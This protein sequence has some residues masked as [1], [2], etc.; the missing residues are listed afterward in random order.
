MPEQLL[1][2]ATPSFFTAPWW[3]A[4]GAIAAGIAALSSFAFNAH[5]K[6]KK[7][8]TKT[9]SDSAGIFDS[10]FSAI[11]KNVRQEIVVH[12]HGIAPQTSSENR[13]ETKKPSRPSVWEIIDS[14]ENATPYDR[15]HIIAKYEGFPVDWRAKFK[16]ISKTDECE[17]WFVSFEIVP[18]P[19]DDDPA[20]VRG[21]PAWV[22]A[23]LDVEV[24]P[25]LKVAKPDDLCWITGKI[26]SLHTLQI[27][28]QDGA[29]VEFD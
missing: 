26:R 27:V 3:T 15:H 8:A 1:I 17:R 10:S 28:L 23:Y 16:D 19:N 29:S 25:H 9:I 14:I 20:P 18:F 7:A 5:K 22:H 12:H 4:V 2:L 6:D 24:Y 13:S 11:G 21:Y